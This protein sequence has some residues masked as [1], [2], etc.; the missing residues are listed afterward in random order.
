MENEDNIGL[1]HK[2]ASKGQL[3]TFCQFGFGALSFFSPSHTLVYLEFSWSTLGGCG[4]LGF[5]EHEGNEKE[6]KH[7]RTSGLAATT[8]F[9][10]RYHVT[11]MF[12]SRLFPCMA[13]ACG[14]LV[15]IYHWHG[16][17]PVLTVDCLAL[18]FPRYPWCCG[19]IS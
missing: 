4:I 12:S 2:T 9:S 15:M 1:I 5:L 14:L 3:V 7:K 17:L 11:C 10:C 13:Y 19:F 8:I 18:S 6:E 16:G